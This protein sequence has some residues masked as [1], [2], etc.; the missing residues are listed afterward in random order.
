MCVS[1][2]RWSLSLWGGMTKNQ[3]ALPH[4]HPTPLLSSLLHLTPPSLADLTD[5]YPPPSLHLS[6]CLAPSPP[7]HTCPRR[8]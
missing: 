1:S 7:Q 5:L 2:G 6:T 4:L 3:P 8:G